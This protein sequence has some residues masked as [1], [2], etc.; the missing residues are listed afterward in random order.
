MRDLL[1]PKGKN[2]CI[3]F[4][5]SCLMAAPMCAQRV[6]YNS[7]VANPP[8]LI[9]DGQ[10]NQFTSLTAA[11]AAAN[12][13]GL[14]L[15]IT[16]QWTRLAT[17][18]IRCKSITMAPG[19]LLRPAPG[20][21]LTILGAFYSPDTQTLDTSLAGAGS[22]IFGSTALVNQTVVPHVEWFGAAP[23]ASAATNTLAL[24]S[25]AYAFP[26]DPGGY[27]QGSV[28]VRQGAFTIGCGQFQVNGTLYLNTGH[29]FYSICTTTSTL[30][31]LAS[32]TF[33]GSTENFMIKVLPTCSDGAKCADIRP[34]ITHNVTVENIA[35]DCNG[36]KNFGASGILYYGAETSIIRKVNVGNYAIRGI[37]VGNYSFVDRFFTN[38]SDAIRLEDVWITG[39]LDPPRD[40]DFTF[41]L[42]ASLW[43][44]STFSMGIP[45]ELTRAD[46]SL[47]KLTRKC[48]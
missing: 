46:V 30:L 45:S 36:L 14:T 39:L 22:I 7:G 48:V 5:S 40:P 31:R 42:E 24:Q 38:L 37:A 10:N 9:S 25:T 19:G 29:R 3:A 27:A 2:Q 11:C 12:S 28:P 44:M 47:G 15:S 20:Q 32:N 43:I 17:Q 23:G 6:D 4:L 8:G 16:R 33:T 13:A 26:V 1:S 34:N 35:L 41:M 18:T 21:V